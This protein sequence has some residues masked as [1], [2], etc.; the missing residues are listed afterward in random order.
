M[1]TPL[2]V[3][4]D[5]NAFSDLFRGE[6]AARERAL[7]LDLKRATRAGQLRLVT[8]GWT[9]EELGGLAAS[10]WDVYR[11]I[12]RFLLDVVSDI[13]EDTR[14]LQ[15]RELRTG[16]PLRRHERC[17]G[18]AELRLL[19]HG[20]RQQRNAVIE[21]YAE[22]RHRAEA[23]QSGHKATRVISLEKLSAQEQFD[24][25]DRGDG[26]RMWCD[27]LPRFIQSWT[28]DLV[29][30]RA[31]SLRIAPPT[32]DL[33]ERVPTAWNFVAF[34]LARLCWYLRDGRTI[35]RGDDTDAHHYAHAC[36]ADLFVTGDDRLSRI[37]ALIP[38]AAAN[39]VTLEALAQRFLG[40]P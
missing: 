6:S 35:E 8:S 5:T 25:V 12:G 39:P 3:Y 31:K 26:M 38:N 16:R 4:F 15:E 33:R 7:R 40:W 22:H 17:I 20:I 32:A 13:F 28:A 37:A 29:A 30:D 19:R 18:N 23:A 27:E 36:Y 10:H 11:A 34:S 14:V 21:A 24:G 2:D 9:L 1:P